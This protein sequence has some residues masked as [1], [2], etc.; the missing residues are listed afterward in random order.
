VRPPEALLVQVAADVLAAD[1]VP[2]ALNR[3]LEQGV[4]ALG[5]VGVDRPARVLAVG[6]VDGMVPAGELLADLDVA[7]VWPGMSSDPSA[8]MK[9]DPLDVGVDRAGQAYFLA[10][11]SPFC[12]VL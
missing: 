8:G 5:G 3:P 12:R 9:R 7:G 4:E 6:V 10:V 1:V 2:R 11:D